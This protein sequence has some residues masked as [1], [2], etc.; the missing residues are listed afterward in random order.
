MPAGY[1]ATGYPVLDKLL[2]GGLLPSFAVALTSPPCDERD[3][4]VKSYLETGARNGAATFY[5]TINP[6][7]A[8]DF[9][10]RYPSNFCL[11]VCSP[12]AEAIVR[13]A[14]NVYTLKGIESL[15][16][17]TIALT[18]AIRKLDPSVKGPKRICVGLVS[19]ALLYH[20]AVQTRMWLSELVTELKSAKFTTLAV[21][22]PQMHPVEELHAILGLFEGE[23]NISERQTKKLER[24]LKVKRMSNQKYVKSE[25]PLTEK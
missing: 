5:V 16:N 25:T 4:L 24:F 6:D 13:G 3:A 20:R 22:D 21:I 18:Q 11:F 19:D 9:A 23:I 8:T 17:I 10:H 12:Q 1:V 7:F 15:T 14:P 2:Y